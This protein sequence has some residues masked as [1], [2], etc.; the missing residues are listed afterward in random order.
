MAHSGALGALLTFSDTVLYP[1]YADRTDLWGLTAMEDQ[2]LGGLIM[3]IPAGLVYVV[4]ALAMIVGW[5]RTSDRRA[6]T[7][8]EGGIVTRASLLLFLMLTIAGCGQRKE[9]EAAAMTGG[10]PLLGR[11]VITRVGCGACHVI[12]GVVGANGQVGPPLNGIASRTYIGGVLT[13]TPD[14]LVQW[15]QDPPAHSPKT[16]MPKL[17]LSEKDARDV[18]AYLYTLTTR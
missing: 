11:D 14:N 13:N 3:W 2:Q 6:L 15:L 16:A 18:T 12:P 10:D 4:A 5:L 7:W 1:T 17:N 8:I 9:A